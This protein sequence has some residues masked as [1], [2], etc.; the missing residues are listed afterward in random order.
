MKTVIGMFDEFAEAQQA[1]DQ[2]L[3]QGFDRNDISIAGHGPFV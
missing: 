2:L 1:I 3:K